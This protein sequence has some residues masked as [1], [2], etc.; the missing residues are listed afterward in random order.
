MGSSNAKSWS[1]FVQVRCNQLVTYDLPDGGF[2]QPS[3]R[4]PPKRKGYSGE[5][6]P[7]TKKRIETAVDCFLQLAPIRDIYNP[8]T[9]RRHKFQLS[10][11]T[12]TI[13]RHEPVPTD[14]AHAALKVWLQ[15]FKRP[16][17]RRK[18]SEVM[19]TYLWKA[20]L[21]ERGQIHYHI[22]TNAWLH[23]I[24]I[25]R[26]WNDIQKARGWLEDYHKQYRNFDPNSTDVHSI[27]K[28]K[29]V[30]RYLTKYISK[31]Q[32]E[33]T[34]ADPEAGYPL[35]RPVTL[36]GKVWGCSEDLKGRKRF[37]AKMDE[38]TWDNICAAY[39]AGELR[40][41]KSE[42]CTFIDP[43]TPPDTLLSFSHFAD[44]EAWKAQ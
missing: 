28:I 25:R 9:K 15:H 42:R 30:R 1:T 29:D 43:I 23:L 33:P 27:H 3:W 32:F 12:L 20:E 24:E 14:E 22:T 18:L 5:V 41:K 13:A 19:K 7:S 35:M 26:V 36:G 38:G 17:H 44:Y 16:W 34:P 40:I 39:G 4:K 8:I 21:Q 31:Q 10:F 6:T 2:E 37:S 11:I